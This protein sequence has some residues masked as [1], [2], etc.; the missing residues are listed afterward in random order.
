MK[1]IKKVLLA[2][3]LC[4]ISQGYIHSQTTD[5]TEKYAYTLLYDDFSNSQI[6]LNNW[7]IEN[8]AYFLRTVFINSTAT[9]SVNSGSLQ[10]S[11]ISCPN[12]TSGGTTSNWAGGKVISKDIFQYG[13]FESRIHFARKKGTEAFFLL[14]GGNEVP[15]VQ[16]GLY[17]TEIDIAKYWWDLLT[18][19]FY[20]YSNEIRDYHTGTD[21]VEDNELKDD[22][23]SGDST[24]SFITFK[25]IWTP[26]Y[27]RCYIDDFLG[28]EVLNTG[29]E[30]FPVYPSHLSLFQALGTDVPIY[31]DV[32]QTTYVDYV[33]V[34]KFFATPKITLNSSVICTAGTATMDV[35]TEASNITWQLTP[36][37][38]F[39]TS[40]G[41]EKVA[42]IVKAPGAQ[43]LGKITYTFQMPSGETFTAAKDFWVGTPQNSKISATVMMGPSDNQLCRN[44]DMTIAAGH[45]EATAQGVTKLI[46]DF[47]AWAPYFQYFDIGGNLQNSRPVFR[48]TSDA[49]ASQT[50][51]IYAQNSCGYS[52]QYYQKVF[53]A[54][55]CAGYSLALSPNPATDVT[56]ATIVSTSGIEIDQTTEWDLEIYD[57]SLTLKTKKDKVNGKSCKF[58]TMGWKEGVYVVRA[59]IGDEII[60][61][62]LMVKP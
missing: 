42:N 29:Q 25:C 51:K 56:T 10:L 54:I 41:T 9:V 13:I 33:S 14:R 34:K 12:C 50:I 47:G 38:L 57:Q 23:S 49:P 28:L 60:S 44:T 62:K 43:G 31:I 3:L 16:G 11:A 21:C 24:S 55:N 20:N 7:S 61:G 18:P 19:A 39:T 37:S 40:S 1:N 46:W 30:W 15:C 6:N 45:S 17:E 48:L 53:Y 35:A 59:K 5:W 58:N 36:T 32:P 52:T 4:V 26:S 2:T 27:V 8:N 22:Y